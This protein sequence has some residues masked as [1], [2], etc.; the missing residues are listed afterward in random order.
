MYKKTRLVALTSLGLFLGYFTL[1]AIESN[2]PLD[3]KPAVELTNSVVGVP[4][5][6][7][8]GP[9]VTGAELARAG[10]PVLDCET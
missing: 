2:N 7:V 5:E 1:Q 9:K 6:A 10:V 4:V 3:G 8:T